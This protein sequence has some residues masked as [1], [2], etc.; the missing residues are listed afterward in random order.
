MIDCVLQQFRSIAHVLHIR[1]DIKILDQTVCHRNNPYGFFFDKHIHF[2]STVYLVS[3]IIPLSIWCMHRY[4]IG[5]T[6]VPV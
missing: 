6:K 1:K 3:Q 4:K 5:S 2:C